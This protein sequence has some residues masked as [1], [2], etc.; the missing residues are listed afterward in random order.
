MLN[1]NLDLDITDFV[2][3]NMNALV[4]VVDALGGFDFDLTDE[5]VVH[6]NNYCV[7]TSE[8]TGKSYERIEPEVAGTYHLNGVQAPRGVPTI[9]DDILQEILHPYPLYSRKRLQTYRTPERADRQNRGKSKKS[10]YEDAGRYHGQCVPDDLHQSQQIGYCI[11]GNEYVVLSAG[12]Y[13]R[14]PV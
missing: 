6:M 13:L 10:R 9:T 11:S 7:G 14:I 3:V 4:E 12:G 2:T 1:Q 5:E 8:I